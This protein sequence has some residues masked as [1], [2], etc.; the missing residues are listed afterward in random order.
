MQIDRLL[1]WVAV[2]LLGLVALFNRAEP[3]R[4]DSTAGSYALTQGRVSFPGGIDH[5]TLF[6]INTQTGE[7]SYLNQAKIPNTASWS[8]SWVT[9]K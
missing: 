3:V 7:V 4:A 6:K 9:V 2:L 8:Y 1:P 5:S